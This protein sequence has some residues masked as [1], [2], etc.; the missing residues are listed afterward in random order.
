MHGGYARWRNLR[1]LF[2]GLRRESRNSK[3]ASVTTA[4]IPRRTPNRTTHNAGQDE[5][6]VNTEVCLSARWPHGERKVNFT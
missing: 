6:I 5:D 1:A 4:R 3:R 2:D